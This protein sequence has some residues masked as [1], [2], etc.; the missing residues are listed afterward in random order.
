MKNS[1]MKLAGMLAIAGLIALGCDSVVDSETESELESITMDQQL[2]PF[3]IPAGA[4][5]FWYQDFSEDTDGWF[6]KLNGW[7][8]EIIQNPS[9]ETA[10][11]KG[12]QLGCLGYVQSRGITDCYYGVFSPFDG[13]RLEWPGDYIADIDIYLDPNTD[14]FLDGRWGFDYIVASSK[15]NENA[16]LRDFNFHVGFVDGELLVNGSNNSD[17]YTNEFKLLNDNNGNNY[18]ITEAGWY[19]FQHSFYDDGGFLAVDLN[20][21]DGNGEL[22]WTATRNTVDEIATVVGGNRYSWFTHVD[23]ANG[24]EI[25][26]HSLYQLV[27]EPTSMDDCKNGGWEAFGFRNQGQCIRYVNTGQD[28]R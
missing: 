3:A 10:T 20:L 22:L 27:D 4:D 24:I 8:G 5:I 19:T 9:T 26:N 13:Y 23:A 1:L 21:F 16:H 12:E 15:K 18:L 11:V 17:F 7:R 14:D 28:S 6:D 25:D 2:M